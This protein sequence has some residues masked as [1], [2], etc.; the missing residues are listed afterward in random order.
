MTEDETLYH[1][2]GFFLEYNKEHEYTLLKGISCITF[3]YLYLSF[4]IKFDMNHVEH[5]HLPS[6]IRRDGSRQGRPCS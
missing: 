4:F 2:P 6:P 1:E 3:F 5:P